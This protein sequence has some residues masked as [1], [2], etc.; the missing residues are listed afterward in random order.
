MCIEAGT[1]GSGIRDPEGAASGDSLLGAA[2]L[3]DS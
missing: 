1:S 3:E 2:S